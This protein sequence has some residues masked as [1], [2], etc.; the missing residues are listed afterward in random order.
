MT[1]S[2]SK[3]GD[4]INK[5]NHKDKKLII[6]I[7]TYHQIIVIFQMQKYNLKKKNKKLEELLRARA[8]SNTIDERNQIKSLETTKPKYD[9]EKS[10]TLMPIERP[11]N[12]SAH[13][14]I[15][16]RQRVPSSAITFACEKS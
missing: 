12:H 8:K 5:Q 14:Q 10:C 13:T 11:R 6:A 1:K 3:Q 4:Q 9:I 7:R 16:Q 15:V 2:H